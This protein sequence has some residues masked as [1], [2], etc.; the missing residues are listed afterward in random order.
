MGNFFKLRMY[1]SYYYRNIE[2]KDLK[3]ILNR[4]YTIDTAPVISLLQ[5]ISIMLQ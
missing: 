2:G 3:N 4:F 5:F 1:F